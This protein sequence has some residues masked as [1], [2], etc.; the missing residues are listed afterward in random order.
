MDF[1]SECFIV[2]EGCFEAERLGGDHYAKRKYKKAR[3]HYQQQIT[4][5]LSNVQDF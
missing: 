1:I 3:H 5:V 4:S 2:V